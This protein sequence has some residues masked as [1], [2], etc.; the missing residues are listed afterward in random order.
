M[1]NTEKSEINDCF[2]PLDIGIVRYK[3]TSGLVHEFMHGES[4]AGLPQSG[5]IGAGQLG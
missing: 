4:P 1:S 5:L 2:K 3:E